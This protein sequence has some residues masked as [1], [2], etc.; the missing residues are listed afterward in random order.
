M[1]EDNLYTVCVLYLPE[2]TTINLR[3]GDLVRLSHVSHNR[4]GLD[5]A[6]KL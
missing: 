5:I 1:R 4:A 2:L 3:I 6:V